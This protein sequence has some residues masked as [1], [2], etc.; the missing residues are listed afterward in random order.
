MGRT[1]QADSTNQEVI[2]RVVYATT[3]IPVNITAG[4]TNAA[5]WYRRSAAATAAIA[6]TLTNLAD[7]ATAHVDGGIIAITNG[8]HLLNPQDAAFATGVSEV[9]F[10]GVADGVVVI[11]D[12]FSI[13]TND[14]NP[15]VESAATVAAAVRAEMDSN[16]VELASLVAYAGVIQADTTEIA[17]MVSVVGIRA[18]MDSNSTQLASLVVAIITDAAGTNIGSDTASLVAQLDVIQADTT[19]IASLEN[20]SQ[21]TV[22]A[23]VSA[24]LVGMQLDELCAT[25][26]SAQPTA[27]SFLGDLTS[28]D[29]GDQRFTTNA[30]ELSPSGGA[31]A[32][33]IA[34]AVWEHG[35]RDLTSTTNFNDISEATVNA[36]C[37]SA[38]E[39]YRLHELMVTALTG[40]P[41]AG[42]M[43]GDLT[44]DD[45]GTQ[46][47][48]TN[49]LELSPSGGA[50]ATAIATACWE[51][52]ER[53][54]SSTGIADLSIPT[55][56][57]N[58]QEMDSNSAELA[59][60]VAYCGVI[61]ADTT[62]IAS[63][64]TAA[65]IRSEIDANSTQ[66]A[67]LVVGVITDA[68]ATNVAADIVAVKAVAD[69]IQAD[70]TLIVAASAQ[71]TATWEHAERSLS[72]TG[73]SDLSIPTAAAIRTEMDSNSAEF[74]SLVVAV[75]T[76]AAGTNIGSDTASAIAQ[77]DVIQA[78]TTV[79]APQFASLVA[80]V[81]TDAAGSNV[82]ADIAAIKAVA[83]VIQADTTLIVEASA[84]ASAV[85]DVALAELTQA[86]PSATPTL[87][88]A[89]MLLYM[90]LR[91][92]RITTDT[93]DA[94][95]NDAGT[96]IAKSTLVATSATFTK[97]KMV[98]G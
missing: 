26:I 47:F 25:A 70:T 3:G 34:T 82:A 85:K 11:G 23:A 95:Y 9:M 71:A 41:Q 50:L 52:A 68:A 86:Q 17:N 7:V 5:F 19:E 8:Y 56:V 10:G 37:D 13:V 29:A 15:L 61:Q 77:L 43:L 22:Q 89:L 53:G 39:T 98:S 45:A 48:N 27:G 46:Q 93:E 6:A 42:S 79:I 92:Q 54:L 12:I 81:I 49:A 69:V 1:V 4:N 44:S 18:E 58:R 14:P 88:E 30:L 80:A 73:I 55:A 36:A 65:G 20:I 94:V 87:E 75:I 63:L 21:A 24:A 38:L 67:S 40:Q 28:D 96:K 32:T 16:S 57:E 31:L 62:E 64:P 2:V 72:T 84:V 33:A 83:D 97:D 74:A 90:A 59:S 60:I 91:N 76:D 78:D 51:H 35:A 66:L